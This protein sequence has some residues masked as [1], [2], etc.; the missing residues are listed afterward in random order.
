MKEQFLIRLNINSSVISHRQLHLYASLFVFVNNLL[1]IS[2]FIHRISQNKT[3]F[4]ELPN[5]KCA[6]SQFCIIQGA[7][8]SSCNSWKMLIVKLELDLIETII[9]TKFGEDLMKIT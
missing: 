5:G 4:F 1:V 3:M 7:Y 9:F 6:L 8:N 2:L